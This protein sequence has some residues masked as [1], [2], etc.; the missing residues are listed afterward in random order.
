MNI[1]DRSSAKKFL[2]LETQNLLY[3]YFDAFANLYGIVPLYRALRI[4]QK[5][6]PKL[7]LT[8]E[9]FLAFVDQLENEHHFYA[10]VAEDEAYTDVPK[11]T[12]MKRDLVS[13]YLY[14][15]DEG[16]FDEYCDLK[17]EQADKPFFIPE[18]EELLKYADDDYFE[19]T[20][21]SD[22]LRNYLKKVMKMELADDVLEELILSIR[23]GDGNI[24]SALDTLQ[25][26]GRNI[27][28]PSK[29]EVMEFID[30]Y[31]RLSD[32][33]RMHGNRGFTPNEL[34]LRIG[35]PPKPVPFGRGLGKEPTDDLSFP[36]VFPTKKA[37][38]GRNDPC[39]CGSG[40][41]YKHC[42]GK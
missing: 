19:K 3:M 17:E 8:E 5:Q 18:K 24:D 14:A 11:T 13:E 29:K 41:K 34:S 32:N 2:P 26:F 37:K 25:Y 22:A 4:I 1:T 39:P 31:L 21:E 36:P 9:Q 7:G 6:N 15:L 42:C 38:P 28:F 23:L 10:I 16:Y 30:L 12:P 40:K 27:Y 35:L 33:T 20:Q